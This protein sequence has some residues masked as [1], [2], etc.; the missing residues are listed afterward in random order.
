MGERLHDA[1]AGTFQGAGVLCLC[2]PCLIPLWHPSVKGFSDRRV[3]VYPLLFVFE[4]VLLAPCSGEAGGK[5]AP[6]WLA[7]Y[8]K[9]TGRLL[10]PAHHKQALLWG[11]R[12]ESGSEHN[13]R[14]LKPEADLNPASSHLMET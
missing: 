11:S 13:L 2:C 6:E 14:D 10:Q 1:S 5:L 8:G 9:V 3:H 12:G 4:N 7:L